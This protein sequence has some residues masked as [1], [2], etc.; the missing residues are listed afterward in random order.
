M[1]K[2]QEKPLARIEIY[3]LN[4]RKIATFIRKK[5]ET[6]KDIFDD[7]L[8]AGENIEMKRFLSSVEASLSALGNTYTGTVENY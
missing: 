3:G 1:R 7:K 8:I 6:I 4:N 5:G 2:T